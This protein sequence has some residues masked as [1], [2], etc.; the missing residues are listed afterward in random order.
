MPKSHLRTST[1]TLAA[2][3]AFDFILLVKLAKET[4]DKH[5]IDVFILERP[6]RYDKKDLMKPRLNQVANGMLM[7]LTNI[8]NRVHLVRLPALDNLAGRARKELF[9]DDGIHLTD[10]GHTVLE[11]EIIAGIKSIY[12]DVKPKTN[13]SP[14]NNIPPPNN[15]SGNGWRGK[16]G[17][18]DGRSGGGYGPPQWNG[19]ARDGAPRQPQYRGSGNNRN[20]QMYNNRQGPGMQ[21]MYRDFM[22]FMNNGPGMNRGGRRY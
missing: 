11:T 9:K 17:G 8:L 2:P 22:D 12:T 6:A 13:N 1:E 15:N 16:R 5:N 3:V 7:P 10:T 14:A 19:P 4:A 18:Y 20:N 21:D